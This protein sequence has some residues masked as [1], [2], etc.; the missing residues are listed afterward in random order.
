MFGL[1]WGVE[2]GIS[3]MLNPKVDIWLTRRSVIVSDKAGFIDI[4]D[5]LHIVSLKKKEAKTP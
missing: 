5:P 2:P 3:V 4:I 1:H